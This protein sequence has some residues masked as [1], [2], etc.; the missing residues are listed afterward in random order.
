MTWAQQEDGHSTSVSQF[1]VGITAAQAQLQSLRRASQ[2]TTRE[3]EAEGRD[4]HC[5]WPSRS[6][7]SG[8]FCSRILPSPL[9]MSSIQPTRNRPGAY[10]ASAGQRTS[11]DICGVCVCVGGGEFCDC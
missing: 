7:R 6:T 3:A 2:E 5:L 4:G 1:C 11:L 9:L 8:L 10:G